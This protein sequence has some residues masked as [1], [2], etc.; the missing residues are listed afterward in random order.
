MHQKKIGDKVREIIT[1]SS[2]KNTALIPFH[3]TMELEFIAGAGAV[4]VKINSNDDNFDM[5]MTYHA[6]Q[7]FLPN[8]QISHQDVLNPEILCL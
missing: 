6:G 5:V 8:Q 4:Q 7:F 1:D 3:K 2:T